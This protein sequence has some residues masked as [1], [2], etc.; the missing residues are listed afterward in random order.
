MAMELITRQEVE[1]FLSDVLTKEEALLSASRSVLDEVSDEGI[2]LSLRKDALMREAYI[3]AIRGG[4]YPVQIAGLVNAEK[5]SKWNKQ[6]VK[7]LMRQMPEEAKVAWQRAKESG[8]F[9]S[10]LVSRGGDPVLVGRAGRGKFFIA[11]WI[12]LGGGKSIGF[13]SR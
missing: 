10:Y 4:F 11:G 8:L 1:Q 9:T 2:K 5:P 7:S 3:N 6:W 12:N 13:V